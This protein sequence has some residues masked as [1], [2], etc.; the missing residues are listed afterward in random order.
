MSKEGLT[1]E[2]AMAQRGGGGDTGAAGEE[3]GSVDTGS[4][5]SA[6]VRGTCSISGGNEGDSGPS[7]SYLEKAAA[8][9][10]LP[11]ATAQAVRSADT[12][13]ANSSTIEAAAPTEAGVSSGAYPFEWAGLALHLPNLVRSCPS[14]LH[15][16]GRHPSQKAAYIAECAAEEAEALIEQRRKKLAQ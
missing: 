10:L 8:Q 9:G 5:P 6:K 11:H 16:C 1:A 7:P 14:L 13:V 4:A 15:L 3:G 2:L 12:I